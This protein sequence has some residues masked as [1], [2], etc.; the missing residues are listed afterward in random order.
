[1]PTENKMIRRIYMFSVVG[2]IIKSLLAL[3]V[4]IYF[5][6]IFAFVSL[7]SGNADVPE[8]GALRIALN[9][10][11][12]DQRTADDFFSAA[13]SDD[14]QPTEHVLRTL[15]KAIKLA[16]NDDRIT[17][18]VLAMHNMQGT[19]IS[20]IEELGQA[21]EDFK[22]SGKPVIAAA[23]SYS[24]S[25][26]LLASYA[27]EILMHP[28]GG[29]E[30]F[31]LSSYQLYL[32][33]ALEKLGV[34]VHVFR[35]GPHKSAVEPLIA[36]EMSSEAREQT[37]RILDDLWTTISDGIRER[38]ELSGADFE[39]Y[40]NE[41]DQLMLEGNAKLGQIA[42]DLNLVDQKDKKP[43]GRVGL[44]VAKGNI[45][46][47]VQPAG[48]IGGD[49]LAYQL[50]QARNLNEEEKLDALVLRV[51]SPGGSAFASEVIRREIELFREEGVPVFVSMGSLAASGGY[52]IS[53]PANEIW[54]TPTTITGSIGAF[55]ALP[56]VEDTLAKVGLNSDGVATGPLAGAFSIDR[57]LSEQTKVIL[58]KRI[59]NLY[60]DFLKLV[61][62]GRSLSIDVVKPIA[63]GRVWTG[64]QALDIG[65]VDKLGGLTDVINAAAETADLGEDYKVVVLRE[66]L[67]PSEML[68]VWLKESLGM[69]LT[70]DSWLQRLLGKTV[71]PIEEVAEQLDIFSDPENMYLHC[72]L[73]Q[74]VTPQ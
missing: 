42:L 40:T 31:G 2:T 22:T 13:F 44:I 6:G 26:Y 4:L 28:M 46:D 25:Q 39:R 58:Q 45:K 24:Q 29:V 56:T 66:P 65:L 47:G 53:A 70:I 9:G 18:I 48:T 68:A 37:Q 11:I 30:L 1:V 35:T 20:K 61:A 51:D 74:W 12:V 60:A 8:E 54:A 16:K 72:G 67:T 69:S 36:K 15:I 63:G 10:T 71:L 57:P 3:L 7:K 41:L 34:N 55:A 32:A 62:E 52:W 59:D 49:S 38:R 23:D 33:E 27:T 21:L 43:S 73:C 5:V 19:S 14:N 64:K 50:K 17:S